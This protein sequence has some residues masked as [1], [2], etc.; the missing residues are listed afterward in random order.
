MTRFAILI[1][2]RGS[3]MAAILDFWRRAPMSYPT[4]ESAPVLVCSSREGAPGVALAQ[5]AGVA[6]EVVDRRALG[7]RGRFEEALLEALERH[8]VEALVLAGFMRV[9]SP[10]F[11]ARYPERILNIHPSLLPSFVGLDAPG[12]AIEAGVKVSGCTIH[13][14]EAA[15][16]AGPIIAQA[17]VPVLETDTS[18]S[19][20]ARIQRVEHA[21][22]PKVIAKVLAGRY[23]R[24][25]RVI[26]LEGGGP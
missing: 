3:N 15:V 16:D 19:L 24:H 11:V 9:L 21:L 20:Q 5:E 22:Y 8:R 12:Q 23:E 6:T 1:S 18:E 13:F 10:E 7:S 17:A 26:A 14:V 2:G 25:G 4:A